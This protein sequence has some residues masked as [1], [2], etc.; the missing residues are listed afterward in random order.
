MASG[1]LGAVNPAAITLTTLYTAPASTYSVVTVNVINT[2]SAAATLDLSITDAVGDTPNNPEDYLEK[3]LV[4]SAATVYE[5]TGLVVG[6]GQTIKVYT[7]SDDLGVLAYG[8][9]TEV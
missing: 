2:G 3:N 5:K 7:T 1:K 9:E 8:I 6:A 4:L